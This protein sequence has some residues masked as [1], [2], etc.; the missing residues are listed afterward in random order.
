MMT[1]FHWLLTAAGGAIV[2]LLAG[3]LVYDVL[4]MRRGWT[5]L[6]EMGDDMR[7]PAVFTLGVMIGLVF[8]FVCGHLWWP[9][10]R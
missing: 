7:R 2:L 8:G 4:A 6:T 9:P 3:L 10:A 1:R 5:T